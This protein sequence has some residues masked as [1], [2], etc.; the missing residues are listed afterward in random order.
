MLEG[1]GYSEAARGKTG[2]VR[3]RFLHDSA[4]IILLYKP[5]PGNIVKRYVIKRVS[6]VLTEGGPI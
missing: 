4:P 3:R 2:G 6:G 1:F 5:H